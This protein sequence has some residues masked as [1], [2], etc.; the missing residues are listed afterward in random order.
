MSVKPADV[1]LGFPDRKP[2]DTAAG[3]RI[4]ANDEKERA[5]QSDCAQTRERLMGSAHVWSARADLLEQLETKRPSFEPEA[6]G[7]WGSY[8]G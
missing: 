4:L 5:E 6:A 2:E 7:G 1:S 3:C 8:D